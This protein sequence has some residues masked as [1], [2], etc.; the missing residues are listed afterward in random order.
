[1][2]NLLPPQEK[3][4]LQREKNRKLA[5]VLGYVAVISLG[6]FVL[7]LVSLR[8]YILSEARVQESIMAAAEK[9]YHTGDFLKLK[10]EILTYNAQVIRTDNFYKKQVPVSAALKTVLDIRRSEGI[11]FSDISFVVLETGA[12]KTII[13]GKSDTRDALLLFKNN[14]ENNV[15]SDGGGQGKIQNAYFPPDNWTKPL[16]VNFYSTFEIIYEK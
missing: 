11:Y 13:S 14:V 1:M 8:F 2:I 12:V 5:M 7:V 6:C 3:E 9:K 15:F 16:N 4:A 10:N